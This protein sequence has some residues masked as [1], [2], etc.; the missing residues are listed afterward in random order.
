MF[1]PLS[2]P[3]SYGLLTAFVI[4]LLQERVS[5]HVPTLVGAGLLRSLHSRKPPDF[6]S[7]WNPRSLAHLAGS[8]RHAF[9]FCI[10]F[11]SIFCITPSRKVLRVC[12][13]RDLFFEKCNLVEI[14][15]ILI[16][17]RWPSVPKN[18]S[19]VESGIICTVH[20]S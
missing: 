13:S 3:A 5:Q 6:H 8:R 20:S 17:Q 12:V 14:F 1:R 10:D 9:F 2:E 4:F 11:F 15:H 19:F 18:N 16:F 7:E